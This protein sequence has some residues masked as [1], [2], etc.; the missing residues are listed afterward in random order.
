MVQT[1]GE[2]ELEGL[3]R[4]LGVSRHPLLELPSLDQARA[5]VASAEGRQ[6]LVE[7]LRERQQRIRLAEEQPMEWGFEAKTWEDA[8]ALLEGRYFT[9]GNEGNKERLGCDILAIFGGNRAQKTY[10]AVKRAV[11]VVSVFPQAR[12]ALCAETERSSNTNLQTPLVWPFLRPKF[13]HLNGKRDVVFKI[14]FSQGN[15]FTDGKL[16]LPNG[17]E[18]YFLTYN[19]NPGDY[20]GWEFGVPAYVYQRI[21]AERRDRGL[22]VP[23]NIGVVGDE[24]MPLGWL[25]MFS[26]RIRFRQA[27]LL[28]TFTPV[29]GITPSVKELLGGAVTVVSRPS[30]LLPRKN[31]PDVPEGQMPY[32]RKCVKPNAVAIYFFTEF[33]AWGPAPGRTYYDEVKGLC[34]G[35]ESQYV[36]RVAY[37]FARDSVARAFP[38]FG[39]WNV[40]RRSQMP[41]IGTNYQLIDPAGDRNW[42]SLWVRV[43]PGRPGSLY[44]YRDWPDAQTYGEWAV[45]TER[46]VSAEQRKG[47]DGD[48]G[49][50]QHGLGF[51]VTKYKQTFLGL[52]RIGML[53]ENEDPYRE[54]VWRAMGGTGGQNGKN[55][56]YG[57]N[58][59]PWA[60]EEIAERYVDPRAGAS[61]HMA[62]Q[63]GTCIIEE[64]EDVQ[65][66]SKGTVTG[67]AMSLTP[68]SGVRIEEGLTAVN[69]LLDWNM[70]EP[71]CPVMNQP[72]LF[73][74]EDCLQVRWMFENYTGLA[75]EKGACKDF[76][77]LVRY[78]ALAKL[79]HVEGRRGRSGKGW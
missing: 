9:E 64:F 48:P 52:E 60:V 59:M 2:R 26:R 65:T 28:W 29:K 67:P 24:N 38:K 53:R 49:P 42:A 62:E 70:E 46:E 19:S 44:I 41:A 74:C 78:L 35:K 23:P 55:E 40:V 4:S 11:Q 30:E 73:V 12:L 51:G 20:E 31:L 45:T 25:T 75:G 63:G 34:E 13:G 50:A 3:Y 57:T 7:R 32:I 72:H 58:E 36:E 37:G 79:E 27:K 6:Q 61:E 22:F 14:N 15:G 69:E 66:D 5:A 17:S 77:D 18:I 1:F 8:D 21:A 16:V 33:N 71:L 39:A 54:R 56:I 10:Y 68:A 47:W 76:A 43:A